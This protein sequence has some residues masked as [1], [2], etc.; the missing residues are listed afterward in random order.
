MRRIKES[1]KN[2]LSPKPLRKVRAMYF[3]GRSLFYRGKR[4]YCPCCDGSFRKFLS[5]HS[6][7]NVLCPGCG[8]LER[9]RL[10]YLYFKNKTDIFTE[11]LKV[12]HFAPEYIFENLFRKSANVTY[13][14]VDLLAPA[15]N[16][17]ADIMHVPYRSTVF[18]VVI[19]NHVL[20]H[21]P[22]DRKA[23]QELYRVLRPDGW[24][25]LQVPI[26]LKLEQTFEDSSVVTPEDR[27]RF[28]GQEDHVR[29]YGRDYIVRLKEAGFSVTVDDYV[30]T[31]SPNI[32][33]K[34]VLDAH[35][36]IYICRK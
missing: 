21:I 32:V 16:V 29:Q 6:R 28:F 12:L 8:S 23:L 5:Y 22:D 15:V 33:K 4:F 24:A 35:E 1:M 18:D 13:T 2:T 26:D 9:H 27:L 31:L 14:T 7:E 3:K 34:Y 20:E 36:H 11:R 19:C 30:N 17:T 25:V 10:L